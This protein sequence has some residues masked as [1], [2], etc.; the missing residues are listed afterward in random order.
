MKKIKTLKRFYV[1]ALL[2]CLG[3]SQGWA[4]IIEKTITLNAKEAEN[5]VLSWTSEDGKVT[6]TL[7]PVPSYQNAGYYE[8]APSTT[9]T[10]TW[11]HNYD[12]VKYDFAV[13]KIVGYRQSV[14]DD[15]GYN[16]G[17]VFTASSGQYDGSNDGLGD[18]GM[19]KNWNGTE[20]R[21]AKLENLSLGEDGNITL[22][23]G[24]EAAGLWPFRRNFK[25]YLQDMVITYTL[26]EREFS[27]KVNATANIP[28]GGTAKVNN[29]T[30][31]TQGDIIS[32]ELVA[33]GS[34]Q[35]NFTLSATPNEGYDFLGWSETP[36]EEDIFSEDA[37]TGYSI[38]CDLSTIA[39]EKTLYAI[40]VKRFDKV[41]MDVKMVQVLRPV[42]TWTKATDVPTLNLPFI[43]ASSNSN[44]AL[45][46]S[47]NSVSLSLTDGYYDGIVNASNLPYTYTVDNAGHIK[48]YNGDYLNGNWSNGIFG[49][50]RGASLALESSAKTS[51]TIVKT[52]NGFQVSC[53]LNNTTYYLV[54]PSNNGAFRIQ[55]GAGALNFYIATTR[56]K[57]VTVEDDPLKFSIAN[58]SING[59][60][61]YATLYC[62]DAYKMPGTDIVGYFIEDAT[63]VGGE[64]EPVV[65]YHS[66]DIVPAGTSLLL[67]GPNGEYEA[68]RYEVKAGGTET[69]REYTDANLNQLEGT[70]DENGN[71]NSHRV[72]GNVYYYKLSYNK[73]HTKVGFYWGVEGGGAFKLN[74]DYTAY[75]A[76]SAEAEARG[77]SLPGF[78]DEDNNETN[79][80]DV[81]ESNVNNCAVY[82][83]SGVRVNDTTNLPAGIYIR[84]GKKFIVR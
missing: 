18:I 23:S 62:Q 78:D 7:T 4:G 65:R 84:N 74:K 73:E 72:S 76:V 17:I 70:R 44:R 40:F 77:F 30:S 66:G 20:W 81:A 49:I 61:N 46:N 82:T 42:D 37:E 56:E 31:Y 22:T 34:K 6:F 48:C 12:R 36:N 26:T 25:Y 80:I 63:N 2:L 8:M 15:G 32:D 10:L 28:A 79:S 38:T 71:T 54:S 51:W 50:G 1:L 43:I 24:P 16:Y 3:V 29:Q 75:L 60:P 39:K 52:D 57:Y 33:A 13:N 9:Y 41:A 5:S 45:G 35:Y 21:E 64:L 53:T 69:A 83:I 19:E 47:I 68:K 67:T 59:S 11:S 27:A 14:K 58:N 55:T